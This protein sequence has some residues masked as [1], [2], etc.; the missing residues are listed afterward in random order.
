MN[1]NK[2]EIA[3]QEF[4][5]SVAIEKSTKLNNVENVKKYIQNGK[6]KFSTDI[7]GGIPSIFFEDSE[8]KKVWIASEGDF[9]LNDIDSIQA[10]EHETGTATWI[11]TYPKRQKNEDKFY[12]FEYLTDAA[13][14]FV[15]NLI[16]Q[17][18]EKYKEELA[19]EERKNYTVN[20]Q[21]SK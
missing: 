19:S 20:F 14:E 7:E 17:L 8:G 4:S 11:R 2:L 9:I 16:E 13:E 6:F 15:N 21:E 10:V 1:T 3:T 18:I 5:F 12:W